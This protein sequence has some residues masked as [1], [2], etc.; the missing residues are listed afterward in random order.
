MSASAML[1][2]LVL[3]ALVD[4][5]LIGVAVLSLLLCDLDIIFQLSCSRDTNI[6][7]KQTKQYLWIVTLLSESAAQVL[8]G[9]NQLTG[10][11]ADIKRPLM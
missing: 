10:S 5:M 7:S 4:P 11:P 9:V 8:F 1:R 2:T 3:N 6:R